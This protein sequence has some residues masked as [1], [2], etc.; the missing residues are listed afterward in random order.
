MYPVNSYFAAN[1]GLMLPPHLYLFSNEC[2]LWPL[3]VVR[4]AEKCQC[5]VQLSVN[6]TN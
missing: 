1:S 4:L 6:C 5:Q 3:F 2:I